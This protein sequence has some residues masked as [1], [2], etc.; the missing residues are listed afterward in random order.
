METKEPIFPISVICG[1]ND[2]E[3][4]NDVEELVC[5]LENFDSDIDTDCEVRDILGRRLRL[6]LKL[7]ELRELSVA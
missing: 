3:T 6:K 5:N 2:V 7:L 4:Y 1:E